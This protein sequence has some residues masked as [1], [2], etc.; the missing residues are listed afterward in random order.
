MTY[1]HLGLVAGFALAADAF[2][3]PSTMSAPEVKGDGLEAL[4]AFDPT[5]MANDDTAK[6]SGRI[7]KLDC[8]AC[9][10]EGVDDLQMSLVRRYG[11]LW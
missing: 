10:V 2:M 6:A 9:Q 3:I 5:K 7:T 1:K 4:K 11:S 8:P